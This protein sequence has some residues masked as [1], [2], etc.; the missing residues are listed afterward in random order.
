MSPYRISGAASYILGTSAKFLYSWSIN[1]CTNFTD[2]NANGVWLSGEATATVNT[3]PNFSGSALSTPSSATKVDLNNFIFTTNTGNPVM[4]RTL[5]TDIFISLGPDYVRSTTAP[6]APAVKDSPLVQKFD[7]GT[8]NSLYGTGFDVRGLSWDSTRDR[9]ALVGRQTGTAIK[10]FLADRDGVIIGSTLGLAV[11]TTSAQFDSVAFELDNAVALAL[12]A[13]TERLYRFPLKGVSP[14]AP[15]N[16]SNGLSISSLTT[17]KSIAYDPTT[18]DD[19]YVVDANGSAWQIEERNKYTNTLVG[20]AWSLPAAFDATRPPSGLAIEPTNGDFL[21]V[22]NYV[23]GAGAS[24]S[25]DIYRIK[26][27]DG[28]STSFSVN[29]YDLG[30]SATTTTGNWGI[31]YDPTSNRL[32]LS[33][34]ATDKVYEICPN[35]LISPRS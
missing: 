22:R 2:T 28:S 12:D 25:I 31:T 1:N 27:S 16:G 20:S 11:S 8:A 5:P 19:F 10:I 26:R 33:D 3:C 13:T 32:F 30:S 6:N 21:V 15:L 14:A 34:S 7:T 4:T 23:N 29:I 9:L 17:P 35:L 18:P 24:S